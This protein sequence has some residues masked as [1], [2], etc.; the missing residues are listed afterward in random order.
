VV[1]KEAKNS[2]S[3]NLFPSTTLHGDKTIT[4]IFITVNIFKIQHAIIPTNSRPILGAVNLSDSESVQLVRSCKLG[5]EF[6]VP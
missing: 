6:H 5:N 2:P 3:R 4:R 1:W